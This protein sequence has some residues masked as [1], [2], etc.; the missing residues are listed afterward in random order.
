MRTIQ[1]CGFAEEEQWNA[2]TGLIPRHLVQRW[3][4]PS[5][6]LN[7]PQQICK[8]HL[9]IEHPWHFERFLETRFWYLTEAGRFEGKPRSYQ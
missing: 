5:V 1:M 8:E 6:E 7:G 2:E 4:A 3:A 9:E